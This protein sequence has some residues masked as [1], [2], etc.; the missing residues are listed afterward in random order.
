GVQSGE[1]EFPL[2]GELPNTRDGL[3]LQ[4]VR[5][6]LK[7]AKPMQV[8]DWIPVSDDAVARFEVLAKSEGRQLPYEEVKDAIRERLMLQKGMQTNRDLSLEM[9][10]RMVNTPVEIVSETWKKQY[11][12]DIEELK[13]NL[14][15][16]ESQQGKSARGAQPT[17]QSSGAAAQTP[18]EKR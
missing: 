5:N 2:E 10:K 4:R 9:T 3:I 7:N 11:Q 8:T 17:A 13:K 15:Q 6:V 1:S 12:K 16:L 18:A 14:A